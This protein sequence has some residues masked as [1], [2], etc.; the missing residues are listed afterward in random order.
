VR[1]LEEAH[2]STIHGFCAD[3]LRERPVEARIDPLFEVLTE[4]RA[5][6]IFNDAFRSWLHEQ[7]EAPPEGVRRA[8]RRSVWSRDGR[9]KDDGPIDRIRRAGRE[10]AEW[11]DFTGA[12]RRDPFDRDAE[13]ARVIARVHDVARLTNLATSKRDTL[14]LDTRFVRDLSHDIDIA[15]RF[16]AGDP[17]GWEARVIDLA[18]NRDLRRARKGRGTYGPGV[19]REAVWAAHESLLHEL[20]AFQRAADCDLAALLHEEL[21][22][23]IAGYEDLK[24]RAGALDFVDLLL[25]ARDVLV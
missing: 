19:E 15:G 7:L 11:R 1:N 9:D 8:L 4:P 3:L 22:A 6:R 23:V 13:L 20:D 2:V 25:R 17:D 24:R 5:T 16:D 12:W 21:R 10:L 18:E 14:Y